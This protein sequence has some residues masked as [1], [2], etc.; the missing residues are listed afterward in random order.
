MRDVCRNPM[1]V[2]HEDKVGELVALGT[3]NVV[4]VLL[5]S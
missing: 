1:M 2:R 5:G 4:M 3:G